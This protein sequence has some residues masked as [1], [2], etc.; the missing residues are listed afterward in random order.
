[1]ENAKIHRLEI[2][3]TLQLKVVLYPGIEEGIN[4]KTGEIQIKCS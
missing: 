1:M 3:D 4:G 2:K